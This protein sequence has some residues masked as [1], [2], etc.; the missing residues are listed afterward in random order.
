MRNRPVDTQQKIAVIR[1]VASKLHA[2]EEA[3]D[4]AIIKMCELNAELPTAR[5][6]AN[7][8]ATVSQLAFDLAASALKTLI[9]CRS[10]TVQTHEV[11]AQTQSAMGLGPVASGDAWKIFKTAG[12]PPL[13]LVESQAA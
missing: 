2:A 11:L 6:D 5:L 7:L 13:A 8:S 3:I 4:L 9:L 12:E 1:S 10:Q